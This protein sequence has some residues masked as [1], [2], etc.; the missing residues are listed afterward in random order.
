MQEIVTGSF[1]PPRWVLWPPRSLRIVD[2]NIDR[3]Q[4]LKG[5]TDFLASTAFI[6]G[7]VQAISGQVHNQVKASDHYPISFT[8]A[9]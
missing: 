4:R 5:V 1:A 6:R 7:P 3:G 8:L 2:W 9:A